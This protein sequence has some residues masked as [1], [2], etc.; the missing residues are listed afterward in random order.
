MK[1][2]REK[3]RDLRKMKGNDGINAKLLTKLNK[4]QEK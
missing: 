2:I 3:V 4:K 1:E